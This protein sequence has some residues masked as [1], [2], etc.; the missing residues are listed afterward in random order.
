LA[1]FS[2]ILAILKIQKLSPN[3]VES[4]MQKFTKR[5]KQIKKKHP[6]PHFTIIVEFL[7]HLVFS[8]TLE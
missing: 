5:R 4:T 6:F 1:K 2:K 7:D 8:P 3:D